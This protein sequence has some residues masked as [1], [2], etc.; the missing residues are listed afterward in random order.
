MNRSDLVVFIARLFLYVREAA[1]PN[2]GLRVE[3]IQKWGGGSRGDSWC[4][5]FVTMVLDIAF[6]GKSPIL[7]HG[8]CQ[9]VY[10]VAKKNGWLESQGMKG[11]IALFLNSEGRAHHIA[12]CTEDSYK[13]RCMAIAGNTSPDG[14]S[15]NGTGVFE[16]YT[17]PSVYVAYPRR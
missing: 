13:G 1:T 16:H 5:W 14:T 6:A 3:A 9:Y 7:R 10:D 17:F 4:C 11:D 15:N 8:A 12:I 2:T